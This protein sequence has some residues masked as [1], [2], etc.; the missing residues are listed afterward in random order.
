MGVY[1]NMDCFYV[2]AVYLQSLHL[3]FKP[4]CTFAAV[5]S[6]FLHLILLIGP[7]DL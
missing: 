2:V 4:K 1:L 7:E 5:Q 6:S 3:Y